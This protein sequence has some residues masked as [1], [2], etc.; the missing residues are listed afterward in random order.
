MTGPTHLERIATL[1]AHR[2]SDRNAIDRLEKTLMK[3]D[4]KLDEL[5]AVRNRGAGIM[6]FVTL[7][8]L[9]GCLAAIVQW[10]KGG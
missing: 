10:F 9:L 6:W 1:E 3:M 8:A 2:I 7:P 5:I 4:L